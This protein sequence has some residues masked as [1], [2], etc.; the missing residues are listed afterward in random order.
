MGREEGKKR[1]EKGSKK[2][3]VERKRTEMCLQTTLRKQER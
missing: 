2:I 3:R 1:K